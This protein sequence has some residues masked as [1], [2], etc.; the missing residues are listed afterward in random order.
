MNLLIARQKT[1]LNAAKEEEIA[2]LLKRFEHHKGDMQIRYKKHLN[3]IKRDME[4]ISPK[5]HKIKKRRQ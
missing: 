2:I 3:K 1:K 5:K 4:I